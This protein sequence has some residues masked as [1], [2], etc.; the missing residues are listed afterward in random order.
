MKWWH[1]IL[2]IVGIVVIWSFVIPP[3]M[4]CKLTFW[5]KNAC[6]NQQAATQFFGLDPNLPI[7]AQ[8]PQFVQGIQEQF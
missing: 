6:A 8:G 2:A 3:S 1:A 5:D 4:R 7:G